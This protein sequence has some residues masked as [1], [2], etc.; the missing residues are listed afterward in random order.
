VHIFQGH[1]ARVIRKPL[2]AFITKG[3]TF[4]D[5]YEMKLRPVRKGVDGGRYMTRVVR[6]RIDV[7]VIFR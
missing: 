4:H 5:I 1:L 7:A 6:T 3:H 2:R